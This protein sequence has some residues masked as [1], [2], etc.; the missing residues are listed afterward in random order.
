[1]TVCGLFA[2]AFA[3]SLCSGDSPSSLRYTQES[4]KSRA[5]LSAWTTEQ[6]LLFLAQKGGQ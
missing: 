4:L 1:M 3:E 5:S 2:I 6:S